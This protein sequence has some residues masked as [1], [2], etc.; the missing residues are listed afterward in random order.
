M[1]KII[2][3]KRIK[4]RI[5]KID[6][7]NR[8]VRSIQIIRNITFILFNHP[9]LTLLPL[10]P[11]LLLLLFLLLLFLLLLIMLVLLLVDTL[12]QIASFTCI[13]TL[14]LK[15]SLEEF[16]NRPSVWESM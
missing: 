5:A 9:F 4:K 10:T 12:S 15:I 3:K 2:P 8:L 7:L 6:E 13:R 11:H 14:V 1:N 16:L